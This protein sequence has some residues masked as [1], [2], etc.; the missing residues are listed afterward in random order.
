M[1]RSKKRTTTPADQVANI[2]GVCMV[3]SRA[4][5]DA[6][7]RTGRRMKT[8]PTTVI[9]DV[10]VVEEVDAVEEAPA[11]VEVTTRRPTVITPALRQQ[12]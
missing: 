6:A 3:V 4:T 12:K 2:E 11:V 9:G 10:A 7:T 8:D 5:P 1:L